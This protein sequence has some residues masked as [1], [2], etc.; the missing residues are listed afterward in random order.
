M[1]QSAYICIYIYRHTARLL[2]CHSPRRNQKQWWVRTGVKIMAIP[3]WMDC[4]LLNLH[5]I[6][7]HCYSLTLLRTLINQLLTKKKINRIFETNTSTYSSYCDVDKLYSRLDE[8]FLYLLMRHNRCSWWTSCEFK[9]TYL[10]YLNSGC[11]SP[12]IQILM[13]QLYSQLSITYKSDI[14]IYCQGTR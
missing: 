12:V 4:S 14:K 7:T 9:T 11:K 3:K 2:R 1:S 5:W 13:T 8:K 10:S 6:V